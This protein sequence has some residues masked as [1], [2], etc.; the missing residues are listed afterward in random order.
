MDIKQVYGRKW[1]QDYFDNLIKPHIPENIKIYVEPFAGSFAVGNRIE[2][3]TKV[4]NDKLKYEGLNR[5]KVNHIEH[6]DYKE[7]IK[8]WDS[9]DTFFYL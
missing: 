9:P 2:A 6:L 7:C 3:E 8:K 1:R 4:Y 5:L